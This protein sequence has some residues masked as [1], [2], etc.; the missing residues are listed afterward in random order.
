MSAWLFAP[1][2]D[3]QRVVDAELAADLGPGDLSAEA[4]PESAQADFLIE[5]QA[6][7]V[8]CGAAI[9]S[10]LL[11]VEADVRDGMPVEEHTRIVSGRGLAR[12]VLARE[13]TALNFLMHLS[14]VAT[15]TSRFV[16][17]VE[18]THARIVD[19]RKTLPGLRTLQKYAVRCGGAVNHRYGL[20][21]GVMLKDTHL[22]V[23]GN[24]AEAIQRLGRTTPHLI[25]VEVEC[26]T[27]DQAEEAVAAGADV[28]LMDNMGPAD[29]REAVRRFQEHCLIEASGGITLE[30]VREVA[31]TGVDFISVGALTHS[32]PALALHM[33]IR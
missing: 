23:A 30:T 7:G 31:E 12:D 28:L 24:M 27:L 6:P 11:N 19:T 29:L 26:T 14:G 33:E 18:G 22:A 2:S 4:I 10:Y 9:A 8:L 3:W 21:D 13:R 5:A 32:A 1:P 17:A 15:L 25:R 16:K 20:Y